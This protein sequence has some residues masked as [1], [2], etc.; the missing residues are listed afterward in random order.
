MPRACGGEHGVDLPTMMRLMIE[1]MRDQKLEGPLDRA[2]E[3]L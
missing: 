3:R 1:K 2:A